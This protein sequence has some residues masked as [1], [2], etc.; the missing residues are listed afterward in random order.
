MGVEEPLSIGDLIQAGSLDLRL[1]AVLW[2]LLARRASVIVAAGPRLAGKSTTLAALLEMVP[3]PSTF[4]PIGGSFSRQELAGLA[5]Q[6]TYLV[7]N[8]FSPHIPGR[9]LWG[10]GAQEVFRA[11]AE[12]YPVAATL[13][14]D[15]PE[16]I[17]EILTGPPLRIPADQVAGVHAI[18]ILRDGHFGSRGV[19]AA[20][21][22]EGIGADGRLA[23]HIAASWD[24]ER[25]SFRHLEQAETVRV[26]A[27][28]LG[29]S[30][31]AVAADLAAR[32]SY[33]GR[34]APDTLAAGWRE[35]LA[36]FA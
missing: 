36:R 27:S 11:Q 26:L 12:G 32:Q 33:L 8:E 13:H 29:L 18:L 24:P 5:P 2:A 25:R 21:L 19:E 10:Q 17:V 23:V 16:E 4:Y 14:A 9:Y 15:S 30:S 28:R 6:D 35:A 22:M 31:Q 20:A 7:V 3:P 34:M 1:A